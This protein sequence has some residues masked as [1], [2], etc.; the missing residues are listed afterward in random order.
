MI[1]RRIALAGY[2]AVYFLHF[3]RS[4]EEAGFDVHWICALAA[5]AGY[6]RANG[7]SS[8][9]IL[10]VNVGFR[11]DGALPTGARERLHRLENAAQPR[12][13]DIILMDRILSKKPPEFSV[14][15]MDHLGVSISAFLEA[16]GIVM[17]SSWRD[18]A[19]QLM[20]MLV[21]K[22]RGI[23]FVV[24]TRARIPQD[25]YGFCTGHHT[26]GFLALREIADADRKWAVDFLDEFES[27][28]MRPAL[29]ISARGFADVLH[30]LPV[31]ARTFFY[32][33]RRSLHDAGNDYA[34]Y[35]IPRLVL[36]YLR[37]RVNLLVYKLV[38]PAETSVADDAP[39]CLY[40]LHTQP[41]SSIDVVGS[42]F[43]DQIGLVRYISRSL[44]ATHT[45]YVKVHPTD[46]DGQSLAFYR[47]IKAIPNVR[48]LDFAVD[49][50]TLLQ[51][52]S[53]VFALTGTIAYEAGL[54]GKPVVVFARNYFNDLP[55]V[56]YCESPPA[57]PALVERLLGPEF[58]DPRTLRPR[59]LDFLAR[60]RAACHDGELSRSHL[61]HRTFLTQADL[62]T[63]Q[64]AYLSLFER[65]AAEVK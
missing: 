24:P 36:A 8:D 50:R 42:F 4:L 27:R 33:L 47:A 30:L 21:C 11:R 48:L 12:I 14:R 35:P 38:R 18:T 3:A 19:L 52:A 41:E 15:Y 5:E 60:L 16:R 40:A 32:E 23:G 1:S 22:E 2:P 7:V 20:T 45:L 13:N 31:H 9:H 6:L 10:D 54:L 34:R 56:H 26:A 29:K 44:P 59:T 58:A 62:H 61:G 25:M 57:L 53:L 63:A 51:R 49:S 17:V 39:F 65:F 55:T 43:S 37:R 46:V 28:G 64:R